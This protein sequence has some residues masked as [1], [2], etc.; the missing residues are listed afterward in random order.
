MSVVPY[1]PEAPREW[2]ALVPAAAELAKSVANTDF[3]PRGMRNNPAAITAAI[4]YGD[5]IGLG[6]MQSLAK[7][8]VIE[9]RP[10]LAAETQRGLVL[11]AGHKMWTEEA[12]N[13]RVTVAGRRR[14]SDE[15][16]RVTWTMDDAKRAGIGG[17]QNWR[18][19]P[20]QMLH[21]RASAELARALFADAIA[22][23]A[24][25]EEIED[26]GGDE[27]P[28]A[29]PVSEGNR[30]RRRATLAPVSAPAEP[31]PAPDTPLP[32]LPGEQPAVDDDPPAAGL[33]SEA[34]RGKMMALFRERGFVE[35][36]ARLAFTR[37]VIGRPVESSTE[38]TS[39]EAS[40]L[41]DTLENA[42]HGAS[43]PD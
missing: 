32:P 13:T 37:V 21:A 6:P 20:R 19:Y 26:T 28:E 9:G 27:S 2:I 12:T 17:K 33:M 30:R 34:Q 25:T 35:R 1:R 43:V 42:G 8:A 31:T 11:Q 16:V 15:V 39:E 22:G 4:L 18:T 5:E 38:L 7:I 14:D 29:A 3:V 40:K 36:G 10:T 23:L 24:A 41:I